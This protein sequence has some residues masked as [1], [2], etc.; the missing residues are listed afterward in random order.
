VRADDVDDRRAVEG[1]PAG[2]H[3]EEDDA[4]RVEVR[5]DVH[6]ARA[7]DLLGREVVGR[8]DHLAGHRDARAV[9]RGD[10]REPEVAELRGPVL[11][12]ED[13]LGLD[14]AVDEPPLVEV[15]EP[16]QEVAHDRER[17]LFL[18]RADPCLQPVEVAAADELGREEEPPACGPAALVGGD[19]RLMLERRRDRDLAPES[20]EQR[21][22]AGHARAE[23]LHRDVPSPRVARTVDHPRGPFA[24]HLEILELED[25]HGGILP[26]VSRPRAI[27]LS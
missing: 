21:G 11:G 13:V 7:A 4:R 22:V 10:L 16:E 6:I 25:R 9:R 5:A 18:E 26:D 3:L 19:E 15:G 14:V 12:E 17:G 27:A 2:E 1:R 8:A 23:E 20:L 24:Q